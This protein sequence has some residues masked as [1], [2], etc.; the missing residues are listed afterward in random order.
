MDSAGSP[1]L[2]TIGAYGF[3]AEGFFAA[4]QEAEID[5]FC[6]I[7]LRRGMRGAAYAFANSQRLQTRLAE[8]GIR[9]LH[10]P[11]LAPS[12]DLRARQEAA[13]EAAGI[14]KRQRTALGEAFRAGYESEVLAELHSAALLAE[15]Q[16]ARRIVFFCVEGHPAACHR[17]LL[18]AR[19]A[20]DLGVEV[21]HI[22]P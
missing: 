3:D 20:Q 4:L 13:D 6:D 9:Y 15:L 5:L 16:P 22:E 18:T 19:L 10:R 7:R 17:S 1:R 8:L 12:R 14:S 2:Y 11:D 21:R